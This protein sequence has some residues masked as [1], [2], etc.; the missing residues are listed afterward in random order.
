MGWGQMSPMTDESET[1]VYHHRIQQEL[2]R[3]Y[4]KPATGILE[5]HFQFVMN[6]EIINNDNDIIDLALSLRVIPFSDV[7]VLV[8]GSQ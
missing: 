3:K 6:L 8:E 4:K 2:S 5:N 1:L 7:L